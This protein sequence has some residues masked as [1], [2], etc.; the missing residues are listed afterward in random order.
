MDDVEKEI[1]GKAFLLRLRELMFIDK[2]PDYDRPN[3][4]ELPLIKH[5]HLE[6]NAHRYWECYARGL[7]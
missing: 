2:P 5:A 3:I 6:G 1:Q 7:G 4:Y